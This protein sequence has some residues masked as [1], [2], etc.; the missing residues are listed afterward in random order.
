MSNYV[1][2]KISKADLP[3]PFIITNERMDKDR[4]HDHWQANG[5]C[6]IN[7]RY[8]LYWKSYSEEEVYRGID[9]HWWLTFSEYLKDCKEH[10]PHVYEAYLKQPN[11]SKDD[12]VRIFWFDTAHAWDT[13]AERTKEA[14]ER[15][16]RFLQKQLLSFYVPTD[17][18]IAED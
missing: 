13:K 9:V 6:A 10:F 2:I 7:K 8:S 17:E 15:E 1:N 5:Y 16:A 14:V 11:T 12:D 18:E 4:P 3:I